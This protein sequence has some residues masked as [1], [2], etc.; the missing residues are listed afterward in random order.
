MK[1]DL[2][3]NNFLTIPNR[4]FFRIHSCSGRNKRTL[5]L[6]LGGR[7]VC[8]H[9]CDLFAEL[10]DVLHLTLGAR[11]HGRLYAKTIDEFLVMFDFSRELL[12]RSQR[13]F[14]LFFLEH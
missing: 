3:D 11:R 1:I 6:D 7:K 5:D 10:C 12:I 4:D 13:I 8:V 2:V 9:A 14:A